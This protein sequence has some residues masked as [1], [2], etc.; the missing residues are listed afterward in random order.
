M[1]TA[2]NEKRRIIFIDEVVF[3]R[4]SCLKRAYSHKGENATINLS[5]IPS[6][7]MSVIAGISYERGKELIEIQHNAVNADDFESFLYELSERHQNRKVAIFMDNLQVHHTQQVKNLAQSL[8]MMLIYNKVNEP[9]LNPIEII[10]SVAK[11]HYKKARFSHENN[12]E[13]Y[14]MAELIEK[15]FSSIKHSSIK[16]SINHS[17]RL[18]GLP[19]VD[20]V[21]PKSDIKQVNER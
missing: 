19:S 11:N 13:D 20:S 2:L 10:F 3:T 5:C 14:N 8:D 6:G 18:L 12:S 4:N 9:D 21:F 15:A 16:N 7:Y 1:Q 17:M